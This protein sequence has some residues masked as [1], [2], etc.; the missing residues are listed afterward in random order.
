MKQ[1]VLIL[2]LP[3]KKRNNEPLSTSC[4]SAPSNK[5]T[6]NTIKPVT[7]S[8]NQNHLDEIVSFPLDD[9]VSSPSVGG[10]ASIS[11]SNRTQ[12]PQPLVTDHSPPSLPSSSYGESSNKHSTK[13]NSQRHYVQ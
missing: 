4:T 13:N 7:S 12:L 6:T 8:T 10:G 1:R 11:L 2:P 3:K 9:T 5:P